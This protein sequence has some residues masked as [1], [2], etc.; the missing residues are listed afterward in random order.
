[1]THR[2]FDVHIRIKPNALIQGG[3]TGR[4]YTASDE[5]DRLEFMAVLERGNYVID[6]GYV[7]YVVSPDDVEVLDY[8]D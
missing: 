5:L 8:A 2:T 7:A 4:T 1:M 3:Y 6:A